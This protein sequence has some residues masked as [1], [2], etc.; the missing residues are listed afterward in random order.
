[1]YF[2]QAAFR[3]VDVEHSL[4]YT[5]QSETAPRRLWPMCLLQAAFHYVDVEHQATVIKPGTYRLVNSYP[6][7]V[8]A[9]LG[10]FKGFMYHG[11]HLGYIMVCYA[12]WLCYVCIEAPWYTDRAWVGQEGHMAKM[13]PCSLVNLSEVEV[14]GNTAR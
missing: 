11:T 14:R 9:L 13:E 3:Y 2:L 6:R 10:Y 12:F 7:K 8:R 5:V 4:S 1:M